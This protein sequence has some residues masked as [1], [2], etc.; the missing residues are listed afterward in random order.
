MDWR[1]A[2]LALPLVTVACAPASDGASVAAATTSQA[3]TSAEAVL[4]DFELDGRL[5]A[6]T[7]GLAGKETLIVAQLM[8]SVGHL[9][10]DRA[11]ARFERLELSQVVVSPLADGVFEVRY[12]AK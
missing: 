6:R 8:Y 1:A 9:N 10:A 2:A 3:F 5:V 11:N 4:L 7:D 12:H